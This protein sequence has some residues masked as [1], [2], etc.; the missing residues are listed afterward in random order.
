MSVY[1][2]M[3]EDGYRQDYVLTSPLAEALRQLC[4]DPEIVW[5]FQKTARDYV[6][7]KYSWD[8]VTKKT[9]ELYQ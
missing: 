6:C 3:R 9:L 5:G 4:G 1:L 8:D 2:R 7:G